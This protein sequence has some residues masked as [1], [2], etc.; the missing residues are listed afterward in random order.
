MSPL[1][2]IS[3]AVFN[4]LVCYFYS[5]SSCVI[6]FFTIE[7]VTCMNEKIEKIEKSTKKIKSVSNP[8]VN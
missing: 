1:F 4:V 6:T 8:I 2:L 5:V 3:F 7:H